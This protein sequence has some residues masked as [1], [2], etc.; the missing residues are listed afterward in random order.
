MLL[1]HLLM[2]GRF[3][4]YFCQISAK[5]WLKHIIICTTRTTIKNTRTS[6]YST[7]KS[8]IMALT[9]RSHKTEVSTV[10]LFNLIYN[11][12]RRRPCWIC[13]QL[14]TLVL[15]ANCI[16]SFFRISSKRCRNISNSF[17]LN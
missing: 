3:T 6:A 7:S 9:T 11:I 13:I 5:L 10:Q 8:R 1:V 12:T 15:T 16:T 4:P 17:V 14:I 2:W